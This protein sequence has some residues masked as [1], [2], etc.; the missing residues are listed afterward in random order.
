M[1]DFNLIRLLD[2]KNLPGGNFP[3]M[4]VF[5]EIISGLALLEV[6]FKGQ[7]YTWS[8]MQEHPLLDQL[9]WVLTSTEWISQFPNTSVKTLAKPVSDHVPYLVYI[10]TFIP[11]AKVFRFESFWTDHPVF[12]QTVVSSWYAQSLP[13]ALLARSLRSSKTKVCTQKVEKIPLSSFPPN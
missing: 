1:G 8:N 7:A 12:S 6:P 2:N 3:D 5:N 9:D 13:L 4:N 10:D 11:K